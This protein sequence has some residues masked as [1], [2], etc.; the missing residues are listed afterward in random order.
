VVLSWIQTA[1]KIKTLDFPM[2]SSI[3]IEAVAN[4][5]IVHADYQ[6][7]PIGSYSVESRPFVFESMASLV[8][9]LNDNLEDPNKKPTSND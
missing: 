1:S 9:W 5:Y 4:G 6:N 3:R 2:T 8:L 7:R